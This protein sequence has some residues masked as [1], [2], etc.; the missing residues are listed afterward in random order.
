MCIRDRLTAGLVDAFTARGLKAFGPTREA[1]AIEGSKVFSKNLM[2]KYNIPTAAYAVF[3]EP[4]KAKDYV[5]QDVYKR[6][7]LTLF[8]NRV[9]WQRRRWRARLT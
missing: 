3:T 4:D 1:A 7:Y 2:Q 6:Q 9:R 8:V 5:R